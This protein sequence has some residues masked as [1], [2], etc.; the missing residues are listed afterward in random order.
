MD[1]KS[2]LQRVT[3]PE[4]NYVLTVHKRPA[5]DA[6]ANSRG[7]V[8]NWGSYD[9]LDDFISNMQFVDSKPDMTA[10]FAV[11]TH[12]HNV[13]VQP[14][15]KPKVFR[16]QATS[17]AFKA[18]CFDLDVGEKTPYA[19]AK[20][21]VAALLPALKAIGMPAPMLV[22]SGR[23]VH[24][25]WPLTRHIS[26]KNW[27]KISVAL[28]NALAANGMTIDWSKIHDASMV[29]RPV[30][31]HHKKDP[32]NWKQV[33]VIADCPDYDVLELATVLKPFATP[34][35]E[36]TVRGPERRMSPMLAAVL[37]KTDFPPVNL[38]H[39]AEGCAQVRAL[40]ASGGVTDATGADV[41]EPLWRMSLGLAKHTAEP[42]VAV[43]R[44]AGRHRDF[45][46]QDSLDK[47]Y[48]WQGSGPPT[49]AGFERAS[50]GGCV[51]CPHKGVLTT[52]ATLTRGES[53]VVVPGN[54]EDDT[55]EELHLP[56]PY[57]AKQG[58]IYREFTN[59]RKAKD[60]E[61][62]AI[63]EEFKDI[64]LVCPYLMWPVARYSD[65]DRGTAMA[66]VRV[67]YPVDGVKEFEIPL[68]VLS[69]GGAELQRL[70]GNRQVLLTNEHLLQRTRSYLM[71]YLQDIQ[72]SIDTSYIYDRMGW[73]RDGSFLCGNN[74]IGSKVLDFKTAGVAKKLKDYIKP[75]GDRQKW[76]DAISVYGHRDADLHGF[77]FLVGLG[78]IVMEG[79]T[80]ESVLFN[81]FSP[82]S[83]AGK[84]VTQAAICSAWGYYPKLFLF[85]A[86]TDNS[87]YKSFGAMNSLT[88]NIDEIT[89]ITVERLTETLYQIPQGR[90]K[91]RMTQGIELRESATWKAPIMSSS[92]KDLYGIIDSVIGAQ[93]QKMRLFQGY[94]TTS[95]LFAREGAGMVRTLQ[96]N[97]GFAT[98]ELVRAIIAQGGVHKIYAEAEMRFHT[99]YNFMFEGPERHIKAGFVCAEAIGPLAHQLGL[100]TWD[101]E[102]KIRRGLQELVSIRDGVIAN[103]ADVFDIMG[104][105]LLEHNAMLVEYKENKDIP[106]SKGVVRLPAPDSA[107]ARIEIAFTQKDPFAGGRIAI[108]KPAFKKWLARKGSDLTKFVADLQASGALVADNERVSLFKGCDKANPGQVYCIVVDILHH[109]IRAVLDASKAQGTPSGPRM[110]VLQ[111]GAS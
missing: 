75:T 71:T 3:A 95:A 100:I 83:G 97:Y 9:N 26:S 38:D 2:F 23:G 16:T 4:G 106:A 32:L 88:P 104:E 72:S 78:G 25:Y 48:Q 37:E 54:D 76:V 56:W 103:T 105:F 80:I 12:T 108:S 59:T 58:R 8:W 79:S 5:A 93:A 43:V 70:F 82:D 6:P 109:R 98:P 84:S 13:E 46:L 42:N 55:E 34:V 51:G 90:E 7:P 40:L 65:D 89:T 64:E 39:L 18:I 50:P 68:G 11:G 101:Y 66:V 53:V 36:K 61:G 41:L 17:H 107:V 77:M 91:L 94:F 69:A 15:G 45:V 63:E 1:T 99:K 33:Q 73:Q 102:A 47:M 10:Y 62:K 60:A 27:T 20:E 14:T 28:R 96:E 110:A 19:T 67:K 35:S 44:L 30:G 92:N 87:L 49:C 31:S 74:L 21:G 85:P 52:P 86:D 111:G 22:K 57:V 81:F 24:C 29:L